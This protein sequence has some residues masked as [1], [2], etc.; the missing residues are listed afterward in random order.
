MNTFTV[1]LISLFV[2]GVLIGIFLPAL[3]KGYRDKKVTDAMLSEQSSPQTLPLDVV[4]T[5][6]VK[7]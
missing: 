3:R 2:A 5:N 7:Q 6:K 1:L 4:A